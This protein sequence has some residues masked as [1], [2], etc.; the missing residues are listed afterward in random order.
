MSQQK[1][2]R[3]KVDLEKWTVNWKKTIEDNGLL[4]FKPEEKKD[5]ENGKVWPESDV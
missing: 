5:K 1:T 2:E 3:I 4:E